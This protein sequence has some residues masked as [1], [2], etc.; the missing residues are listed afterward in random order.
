MR[1]ITSRQVGW[2]AHT[3]PIYWPTDRRRVSSPSNLPRGNRAHYLRFNREKSPIAANWL[4][5]LGVRDK[6]WMIAAKGLFHRGMKTRCLGEAGRL[7]CFLAL[8]TSGF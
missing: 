5:T 7:W 8:H 6:E 2:A 4:G 3:P 1:A